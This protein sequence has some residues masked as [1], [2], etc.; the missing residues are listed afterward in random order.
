MVFQPLSA[1]LFSHLW[2]R[3]ASPP[4]T[5]EATSTLDGNVYVAQLAT[6]LKAVAIRVS[7]DA[8]LRTQG[9]GSFPISL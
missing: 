5:S 9:V 7:G 6:N 1:F 8:A 2:V 4:G 3:P